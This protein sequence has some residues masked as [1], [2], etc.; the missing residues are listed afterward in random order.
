LDLRGKNNRIQ[1]KIAQSL[2]LRFVL[3]TKHR[4]VDQINENEM[5][6]VEEYVENMEDEFTR[7]FGRKSS[8]KVTTWMN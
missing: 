4:S 6:C 2:A 8:K 5:E 7:R 1:E 3:L